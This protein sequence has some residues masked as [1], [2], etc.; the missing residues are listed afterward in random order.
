M[1]SDSLE[2][3]DDIG[4]RSVVLNKASGDVGITLGNLEDGVGVVVIAVNTD[5]IAANH[6]KPGAIILKI[7]NHDVGSHAE[8]IALIDRAEHGMIELVLAADEYEHTSV[9]SGIQPMNRSTSGK[10]FVR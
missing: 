2:I 6:V 9:L 4:E 3:S 10:A 1:S 7:N 8:A 5:G